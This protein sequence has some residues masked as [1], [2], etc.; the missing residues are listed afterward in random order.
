M[1]SKVSLLTR[2]LRKIDRTLKE[3]QD[4]PSDW[5]IGRM[6]RLV[7]RACLP[8]PD[9]RPVIFFNASTRIGYNSYNAA[10]ALIAAWGLRLAGVP[11][12][13]FVCQSGM[14]RCVLG[15]DPQHPEYGMPC[16]ACLRR[17]RVDFRHADV[18]YFNYRPDVR[19]EAA[20]EGLGIPRLQEF[21]YSQAPLGALVLPA[22]RWRLRLQTLKDDEATRALFR[23]FILS[24]WNVLR[25]F[26]A[27]LDQTQP[28]AVIVFN[29]QFFP[30]AT[31][32]WAARRRGIRVI[33]HEVG[34]HPFSGFFTDGEA[35]AYP[36]HIPD[37]FELSAAQNERLEAYLAKRFQGLFSMAGVRFWPD[38][39]GLDQAFLNKAQQ[40]SQIVPVFTNVIF[41]TSQP[42]ANTV[43]TDMFAWLELVLELAR[44][45]PE[46]LFVIRAHPDETRPGKESRET[47]QDWVAARRATDLPNLVFVAPTEYFSS[48]ELIQHS[49][50]VMI[51]NSTIGLE[52]TIL[53]LP[54]L[55]AGKARFTQYP[56]VFFPQSIPEY[57]AQAEEFLTAVSIEVPTDFIRN[58]RK[59]LYYQL[60]LTSLP[61]NAF[62]TASSHPSNVRFRRFT[63]DQLRRENSAAIATLLDGVL[64]KEDFLLRR[65]E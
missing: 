15:S 22:L 26:E 1:E 27:L 16:K 61:F 60:F 9:L 24:A 34:L 6:A 53:G 63:L 64:A 20:L 57:R 31:A 49:K 13:Q 55:C 28:Q 21:V 47:V 51:Y 4:W 12:I 2:G 58:A 30:E 59:F 52:A 44:A 48:Y 50:F 43:F 10:Y 25:E 7:R 5:N 40:F 42:H 18:R 39:K 38:M 65:S 32:R 37:E 46:T 35:T 29:G 17:S 11:V 8:G 3:I 36:I 54:V 14:V 41:D 45:H 62:L 33:S 23:D 19:L 56:T